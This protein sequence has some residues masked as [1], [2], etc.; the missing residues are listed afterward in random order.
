MALTFKLVTT[1]SSWH[2]VR[3]VLPDM[4][5]NFVNLIRRRWRSL[6][7]ETA[8]IVRARR[9]LAR[10]FVTFFVSVEPVVILCILNRN[11]GVLYNAHKDVLYDRNDKENE[12]VHEN[13]RVPKVSLLHRMISVE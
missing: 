2:D 11:V 9:R 4:H 10:L 7:I 8:T 1:R 5:R 12:Q 3:H 13:L 6:I